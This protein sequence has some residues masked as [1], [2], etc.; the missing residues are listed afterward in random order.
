MDLNYLK[1]LKV[2]S[3]SESFSDAAGK[4][5][6][7]RST[8]TSQVHQME[9]EF[10][11]TLFEQF[12]K[13][14]YLTSEGKAVLP[15]VDNILRSYR[16]ILSYGSD[17]AGTLR[18]AMPETLLMNRIN[19]VIRA[20][21]EK[22]PGID[23]QIQT[24]SCYEMI[25]MLK[26]DSTDI[27]IH[28]DVG[29]KDPDILQKPI[30]HYP[31]ILFGSAQMSKEDRDFQTPDQIKPFGIIDIEVDGLYRHSLDKTLREKHITLQRGMVLGSIAAITECVKMGLGISILPDFAVEDELAK[32][33][34]Q[35]LNCELNPDN[36][37][38]LCSCHR[39]KHITSAMRC[40]L[41]LTE[42]LI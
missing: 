6:Y 41:E 9:K 13:R 24:K 3:E 16:Q 27:A 11:F 15:Y 12:G 2:I 23:L 21:R 32:G 17:E 19:S 29:E 18:I 37:T 42:T 7:T 39:S 36:V 40:F 35:R 20:F 33:D 14:M 26:S 8:I 31:L 25:S 4:L 10:G 1:T 28:Y 34:V 5:G 30:A 38:V 22:M